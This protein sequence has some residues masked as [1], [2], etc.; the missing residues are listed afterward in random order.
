MLQVFLTTD[1]R[2]IREI[3]REFRNVPQ[4]LDREVPEALNR[5]VEK[6]QQDIVGRLAADIPGLK[7]MDIRNA[8]RTKKASARNW[9]GHVELFGPGVPVGKLD[10][11]LGV[12]TEVTKIASAK[13]SA[14]LFYNVFKP[15]Y[16]AAAMYSTAYRITRKVYKNITYRVSGRTKSL[17]G[18]GAFPMSARFGRKGIFKRRDLFGG[19]REMRGPSLF[20]I[21]DNNKAM[22]KSIIQENTKGF[23]RELEKLSER[24]LVYLPRQPQSLHI[25]RHAIDTTGLG[26]SG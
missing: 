21:L 2:Q 5:T 17:A 24:H 16:G 18:T 23:E 6:T 12:K 19:I 4:V 20:Q 7:K 15:K 1:E 14:W 13:Q 9:S 22:L 3:Q 11:R 26:V 25:P 8:T 10:V